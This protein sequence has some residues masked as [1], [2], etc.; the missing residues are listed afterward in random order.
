[1]KCESEKI[2]KLYKNINIQL[3]SQV[4]KLTVRIS[5]HLYGPYNIEDP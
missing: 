4:S 5:Y 3:I 1:M 2:Y